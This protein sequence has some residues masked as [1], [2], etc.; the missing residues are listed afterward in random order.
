MN[1][2]KKDLTR[3]ATVKNELGLHARPAARIAA[4]ASEA[5]SD[6]WLCKNG[7]QA[8]ATSIIDILSM[9]CF[10]GTVVTVEITDP[11]DTPVLNRI[12][13]LFERGF[14]E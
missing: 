11:A 7:E 9:A 1:T 13:D 10:K 8:D 4:M 5:R 14:E 12:I 3:T 2:L 6:I